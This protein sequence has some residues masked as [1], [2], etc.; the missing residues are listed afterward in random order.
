MTSVD[1]HDL[2]DLLLVSLCY[3]LSFSLIVLNSGLFWDDWILYSESAQSLVERFRAA[4]SVQSGY[5]HSFL[6]SL[7]HPILTCR[8]IVFLSYLFSAFALYFILKPK[9]VKERTARFFIVVLFAL[10]FTIN[11]FLVI[12]MLLLVC[13]LCEKK[14]TQFDTTLIVTKRMWLFLDFFILPVAFYIYKVLYATPYGLYQEYNQLSFRSM[15]HAFIWLPVSIYTS[16]IEPLLYSFDTLSYTALLGGMLLGAYVIAFRSADALELRHNKLFF[17][18]LVFLCAANFPYL[19]VYKLPQLLNDWENRHQLLVPFGAALMLYSGGKLCMEAVRM[20]RSVQVYLFALIVLLFAKTNIEF[21]V[22]YERDAL[23]QLALIENIRQN[24]IIREN[25]FFIFEDRTVGINVNQ[26][27]FR[28][29]EYTG[30]LKAAFNGGMR[31]G[32]DNGSVTSSDGNTQ[33][34]SML[35]DARNNEITIP[36][37]RVII[38]NGEYNLN[39]PN[40]VRLKLRRL[41]TPKEFMRNISRV[42]SLRV[43]KI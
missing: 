43:V 5:L 23:K 25:R 14:L 10:S 37:Y 3:L 27:A 4:G 38:E 12:Y 19:A 8:I 33:M 39:I 20:P 22:M 15:I 18:G 35:S 28:S 11:S 9:L 13:V 36:Q 29:Y 24:D 21:Q 30:I 31:T 6:Q 32:I 41:F 16:F 2:K 1:K 17:T 34:P 40:I 42:V 7:P 26:R